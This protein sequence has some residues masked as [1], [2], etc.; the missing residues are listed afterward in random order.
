MNASSVQNT[1]SGMNQALSS[2]QAMNDILKMAVNA[3]Q[4]LSRKM[5]GMAA[6]AKVGHAADQ[7]RVN[8][9]A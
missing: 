3:D 4:D 5:V 8:Y 1:N 7:N 6:E 2:A 9:L